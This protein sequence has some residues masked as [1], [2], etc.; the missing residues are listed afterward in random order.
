MM[1]RVL[2]G[3]LQ[4]C[5]KPVSTAQQ[6]LAGIKFLLR[7]DWIIQEW[8]PCG[9]LWCDDQYLSIDSLSTGRWFTSS[10][11][12]QNKVFRRRN[13]CESCNNVWCCRYLWYHYTNLDAFSSHDCPCM[14]RRDF[15]WWF[16]Y[17]RRSE[18]MKH[19]F[20]WVLVEIYSLLTGVKDADWIRT[21]V[22][23]ILSQISWIFF[24][25][26]QHGSMQITNALGEIVYQKSR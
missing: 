13:G 26:I 12:V 25:T 20:R 5:P 7:E 3:L 21:E 9:Y 16:V 22:F 8:Q 24:N 6:P 2:H 15:H 19:F 4:L 1:S 23:L 18:L 11:A 10:S 17:D 14:G